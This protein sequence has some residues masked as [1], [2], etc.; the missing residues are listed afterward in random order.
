MEI[1]FDTGETLILPS[2]SDSNLIFQNQN[3]LKNTTPRRNTHNITVT[4]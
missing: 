2:D 3:N 1:Q 4:F